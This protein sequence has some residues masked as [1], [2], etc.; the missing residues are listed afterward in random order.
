MTSTNKTT[1]LDENNLILSMAGEP[2]ISSLSSSNA[3]SLIAQQLLDEASREVQMEG[4]YWNSENGRTF[5]RDGND[6]IPLPENL[7]KIDAPLAGRTS[8]GA[9]TSSYGN[10]V[11]RNGILYDLDEKTDTFDQDLTL[12]STIL[13]K[14]L[15]LPEQTRRYIDLRPGRSS[16]AAS[17][18]TTRS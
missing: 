8:S 17:S 9:L 14:W 7:L 13:L 3:D 15:E 18:A 5:Q 2:P 6:K 11:E 10:Y 12:N 16:F 4:W 1:E